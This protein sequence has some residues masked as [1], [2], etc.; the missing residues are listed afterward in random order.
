MATYGIGGYNPRRKSY[1]TWHVDATTS[2]EARKKFHKMSPD[3]KI[4]RCK[5]LK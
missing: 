4:S 5:K 2:A 1:Q 3:I